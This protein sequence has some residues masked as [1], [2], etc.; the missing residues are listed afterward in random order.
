MDVDK[1]L[2]ELITDKRK[3]QGPRRGN[4]PRPSRERGASGPT[5]YVVGSPHHLTSMSKTP[6]P[7]I[8]PP[9][10]SETKNRSI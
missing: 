10:Q 8:R 4:G 1:P 6:F 5:P 3:S 7:S 9:K 2:D